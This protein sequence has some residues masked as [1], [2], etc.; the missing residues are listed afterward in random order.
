[1]AEKLASPQL[2]FATLAFGSAGIIILF[3]IYIWVAI[4]LIEKNHNM[5]KAYLHEIEL[6]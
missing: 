1:M 6:D 2:V 4:L 5:K 3:F